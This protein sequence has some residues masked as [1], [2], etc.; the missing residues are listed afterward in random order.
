[1]GIAGAGRNA[2][3]DGGATP[4]LPPRSEGERQVSHLSPD[5][6]M[7]DGSESTLSTCGLHVPMAVAV[8]APVPVRVCRAPRVPLEHFAALPAWNVLGPSLWASLCDN[9][10]VLLSLLLSSPVSSG[11]GR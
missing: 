4:K 11:I 9:S 2:G 1:M 6:G 10:T 7:I 3:A 5:L 8:A